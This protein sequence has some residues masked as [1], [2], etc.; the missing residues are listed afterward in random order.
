MTT[1][2]QLGELALE[3][4]KQGVPVF[5]CSELKNPLTP[6]GHHDATTD[7]DAVLEL[8]E[9][10]G[11]AAVYIGAVMG[12]KSKLFA[13]D[14]DTY[15]EGAVGE[16]AKQYEN[17]LRRNGLLDETRT[18]RTVSG[19]VHYIYYSDSAWPNCK[20]AAGVEVKGEG[21]YIIVPPS[22]GY[23]IVSKGLC[24]A[25]PA[26]LAELNKRKAETSGA[27]MGELKRQIMSAEGFHDPLTII[28]ARR[29]NEGWTPER[30]QND[31]LN[32]MQASVARMP[33]HPRHS[34]W[35]SIISDMK[36]ELGRI[37]Q[38]ADH[39]FNSNSAADK[40]REAAALAGKVFEIPHSPHA[41]PEQVK[42][43]EE[44]EGQWPFA[45]GY[46]YGDEADILSQNY[47]AYPILAEHETTVVYADPKAGKTLF[48]HT[49]AMHVAAGK[50]IGDKVWVAEPR[51][52]LYFA[53]EGQVAVKRRQVA[54]KALHP[55]VQRMPLYVHERPLDL[56]DAAVRQDFVNKILA[57][58]EYFKRTDENKIGLIVIDTL[59]KAMP[60]KDQNSVEDTSA[61]FDVV[62]R[63]RE[64][65]VSAAIIFVHHANKA[66]TGPRGSGN[67][68]AEPDTLLQIEKTE[69]GQVKVSVAMAR[70]IDDEFENLYFDIKS[71]ILGKTAQGFEIKA[72]YLEYAGRRIEPLAEA[73]DTALNRTRKPSPAT[74]ASAANL[75]TAKAEVAILNALLKLGVGEHNLTMV[76]NHLRSANLPPH[77]YPSERLRHTHGK[78]QSLFYKL[79]PKTGR[80]YAGHAFE[81]IV[82]MRGYSAITIRK[83]SK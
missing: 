70:S 66:K 32:V 56:S 74:T 46:F 57:A 64:A 48:T 78:I 38:S 44:Y 11:S 61:V 43:P 6:H 2:R 14:C 3:W 80:I 9:R 16:T 81:P 69:A 47:I 67:I 30:I 79:V 29:A 12:K 36:G 20:P 7:V 33:D 45:G 23:E 53:L 54:W 17:Y 41:E 31:L 39:K 75:N 58:E 42:A 8:F 55:Q 72:P 65:G 50:A 51:P 4:A 28:A 22:P 82:G 13:I 71:H 62:G 27:T 15:K 25:S 26:L 34:R 10:A 83:V 40:L 1:G 52:V 77:I 60:G 24:T 19:G 49:V 73:E 35:K 68:M 21:G 63:L 59:T 5:P 18:H 37:V 76:H